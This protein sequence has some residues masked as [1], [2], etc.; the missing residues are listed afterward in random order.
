[1]TAPALLAARPRLHGDV[2]LSR[3]LL[4][5]PA[6]VCLVKDLR[7]G[8]AF[9]VAGKE[10]FLLRRLDG[11]RSLGEIG[12][13]YARTFG[14]RLA[15]AHWQQLLTLLYGRGLLAAGP[16]AQ[17]G[18]GRPA[19]LPLI[20]ACHRRVRF[21]LT[22]PVVLPLAGLVLAM[23]VVLA[24]HAGELAH[25]GWWLLRHAR[26]LVAAVALAG[27][28]AA[29][30]ELAHGVVARHF[31]ASVT[32]VSL[33]TLH[34]QVDDYL[35]LHSRGRQVAIAL[36]GALVNAAVLLP[37]AAAWLAVQPGTAPR[38]ALA[39]L[40]LVGAVQA[41]VNLVPL[42]PLDGYRALGHALRTSRLATESRRFLRLAAAGAVGRGAG[43]A[44]YPRR[45]RLVYTGYGLLAIGLYAA[46]LTGVLLAGRA[47]AIDSLGSSVVLVTVIAVSMTLA[48]WLARP[49]PAARAAAAP[50]PS[51]DE[52]RQ[53]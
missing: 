16:D 17:G 30:H 53:R 28:S 45:A 47:L 51:R 46:V 27:V 49:D 44:A 8:R 43:L 5:G 38:Q 13:D 14:R 19:T 7:T 20:E 6:E 29:L 11:T 50:N 41:L 31:G 18:G 9:E 21:A 2:L 4:R 32:R 23:L 40:L 42:P 12:E 24:L 48:G 22:R 37:L 33:V 25:G 1:V 26:W 39:G 3:P 10:Q 15:E 36:V 35:Y 52:S 34:C